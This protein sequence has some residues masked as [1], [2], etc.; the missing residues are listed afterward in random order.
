MSSTVSTKTALRQLTG[1]HAE[2]VLVA[3]FQAWTNAPRLSRLLSG[4]AEGHPVYQ[5]DPV[6]VLSGD[7]LYLPLRD[8]AAACVEEFLAS[9]PPDGR[10]FIAGHCS[11]SALSLHVARLLGESRDVTAVLVAPVWPDEE[12]VRDR[13]AESLSKLGAPARPCPEL[14]GDPAA[15][16]GRMESVIMEELIAV[17][18]SRGVHRPAN[19]FRELVAW[20]R[21]WLAFLLACH[22][23]PPMAWATSSA[24]V[25]VLSPATAKCTV[26]GLSDD[27]YQLRQ[28][29]VLREEDPITPELAESVLAQITSH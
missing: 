19:V 13:F 2:P 27:A 14:D 25:I 20:Y 28:I 26:P 21:G 10:I 4:L 1:G 9:G 7:Q 15:A 5:I 22:N 29:P 6:G 24:E 16:V 23:D 11:A 8:L 3:E 12:H 17:A 18:A